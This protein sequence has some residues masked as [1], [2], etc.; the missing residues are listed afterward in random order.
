MV[1]TVVTIIIAV[2]IFVL[3]WVA[4]DLL[5]GLIPETTPPN[6]RLKSTVNIILKLLLIMLAVAW[7]IQSFLGGLK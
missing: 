3:L 6:P 7:L 5:T 2:I 4:I 1:A